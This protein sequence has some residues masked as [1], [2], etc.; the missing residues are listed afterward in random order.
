M[1]KKNLIYNFISICY[2]YFKNFFLFKILDKII[3]I[4]DKI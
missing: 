2:S 3:Q 1:S 4:F